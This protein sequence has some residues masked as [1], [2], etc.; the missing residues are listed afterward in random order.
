MT[1]TTSP[2]Q[3]ALAAHRRGDWEA[4]EL[5]C[6]QVLA[7]RPGDADATHLLGLV[8]LQTGRPGKAVGLLL[9]AARARPDV[10]PLHNNLGLALLAQGRLAE[11]EGGFREALRRDRSFPQAANNLGL[12]LQRQGRLDEASAAYAEAV[13]LE[14]SYPEALANLGAAL[15]ELGR[16]GEA[17][18]CLRQALA[19][20]PTSV[21]AWNN[22][23]LVLQAQGRLEE[24][25]ACFRQSLASRATAEGHNNLGC[26][27]HQAGRAPEAADSYRAALALNANYP[28][29]CLNLGAVLH[30]AGQLPDAE[31]PLRRAVGLLPD[32]ARAHA[33]LG[34][35]LHDLHHLAE[36][37][38]HYL[39][40]VEIDPAY[41]EAHVN[42]GE[43]LLLQGRWQEGWRAFAWRKRGGAAPFAVPEW[44]GADLAGKAILLE[45]GEDLSDTLL[46]IRY[47]PLVKARGG[48]VWLR[49]PAE[50]APLFSSGCPGVD[51][52]LDAGG[53][54]SEVAVRAD[55]ID[56]PGLL[57]ATA[58]AGPWPEGCLRADPGLRETWRHRLDHLHGAKVGI[59]WQGEANTV[60]P[61]RR[62]A[63]LDVFQPFGRL[64]NV[65]L[66]SL[67]RGDGAVQLAGIGAW[68][69]VID[70]GA[71][72][73]AGTLADLAAVVSELDLVVGV[74]APAVHLA[75]A[76]GVPAWVALP[77]TPDWVWLLDRDDSP[78][79]RSVRLFRQPA[80]GKGGAVFNAIADEL[81]RVG[82]PTR[83]GGGVRG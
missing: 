3:D 18:R 53:A 38:Q 64:A 55:L 30:E 77:H 81:Y 7:A 59:V 51:H 22:L 48:Q 56:L 32:D 27:L 68:L 10:A 14:P 54:V 76:L 24:A 11:A 62:P 52:W 33:A 5:L 69:G 49:G 12:C 6:R 37:E 23:G 70:L 39:R 20:Q 19:L 57:G 82:V 65:N 17:E 71:E 72:F 4:T 75:G 35:L 16:L 73:L 34:R 40:A 29:A 42:L 41:A 66:I 47:A 26:L 46:F 1:S 58:E 9:Q 80:P 61:R 43:L 45:A 25:E 44:D 50:L 28:E 67:Q 36:A 78:W 63:P 2:L 8:C 60:R 13:R 83:V 31:A 21:E 74:D 15:R 79:Y